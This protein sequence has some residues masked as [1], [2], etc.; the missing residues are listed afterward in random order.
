[1]PGST[2]PDSA[3]ARACAETLGREKTADLRG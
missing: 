3:V 2:E 1:M